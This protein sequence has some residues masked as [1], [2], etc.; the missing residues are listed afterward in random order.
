MKV[1]LYTDRKEKAVQARPMK[2]TTGTPLGPD[3]T[4]AGLIDYHKVTHLQ[5]TP[6][7]ASLLV[8]DP[9][10]RSAL[11]RLRQFL[12]GG[13]ALPPELARTLK[14]SFD[15]VL[16]NVYGPTE[17]TVWSTAHT[18]LNVDGSIPIGRPLANTR[19][20]VLD[21]VLEPV[22]PG[23]PGELYIGGAGVT[24]GYLGRPELTGE[25]FI[26]DPFK[27]GSRQNAKPPSQADS[28]R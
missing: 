7:M 24:R 5:C 3:G 9:R 10:T 20:Y 11:H 4:I 12:V 16:T 15:G 8:A 25:R 21:E 14:A 22:P 2:P 1:V 27:D 13:E 28:V 17:T 26:S 23:V 19:V 18:V 6:S